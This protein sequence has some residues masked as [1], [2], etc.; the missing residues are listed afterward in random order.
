MESDTLEPVD[1]PQDKHDPGGKM[2]LKLLP[3]VNAFAEWSGD[4]NEHRLCLTREWVSPF[5]SGDPRR[6]APF[7]LWIGMNP[8]VAS[9]DIDDLTCRKEQVWTRMLD[10]Q[11]YVK[12]N[13][14][15]YR[16]TDPSKLP[17]D[18]ALSHD[19]NLSTISEWARA[20]TCKA[21]ILAT[22]RVPDRLVVSF[23][24]IIELLRAYGVP[25]QSLGTTKDG[26]PRHS[27]RIGYSTPL[28]PYEGWPKHPQMDNLA[29]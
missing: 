5:S 18:V 20:A 23:R 16:C 19:R 15:T 6:C 3:G 25:L 9:A 21:V 4:N 1:Q 22:G 2:R 11:A 13:V 29:R 7:A 26:W 12:V 24:E 28:V 8:S 27:S 17:A 14:G 10:L